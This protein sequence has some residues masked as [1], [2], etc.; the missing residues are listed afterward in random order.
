ME[1]G[2]L[3]KGIGGFYYVELPSGQIV[4]CKARGAFRNREISPLAGD[5]VLI[6]ETAEQKGVICEILPRKNQLRRPPLSNL[7][8]LLFVVSVCDP[9]PNLLLLDKLIA[10]TEYKKIEPIIIITKTDLSS[11]EEYRGIYTKAGF[12]TFSLSNRAPAG[13]EKLKDIL[14]GK[15]SAF[16]GNSGVG[17]SSLLNNIDSRLALETAAISKKLG[18]GRHTTRRVELFKLENGGYIADT[19]GFS[20]LETGQYELIRKEELGAC[21]REFAPYLDDCRFTGCSHT[22]EKG[23]AV[24]AAVNSGIIPQSRHESYLAMYEEAKKI[25]D[26]E[27]KD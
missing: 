16:T 25:K 3:L 22:K 8:Q 14:K 24:L 23:C 26:W 21:F 11:G 27:R 9:R 10:I 5:Q 2:L 7:D 13:I 19:P 17:K 6:E 4:E 20:A 12:Q 18:R 1:K 15:I